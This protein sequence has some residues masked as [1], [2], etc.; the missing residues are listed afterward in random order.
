MYGL[1]NAG[2][3]PDHVA[4]IDSNLCPYVIAYKQYV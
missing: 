2:E 1:T 3:A 4:K